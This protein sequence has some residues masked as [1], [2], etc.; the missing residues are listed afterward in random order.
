MEKM[1][2]EK[3]LEKSLTWSSVGDLHPKKEFRRFD[4]QTQ[5]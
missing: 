5:V 1:E 2:I 4:S 3:N